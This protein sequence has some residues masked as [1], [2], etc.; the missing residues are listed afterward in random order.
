MTLST[1]YDV[2]RRPKFK[3][4]AIEPEV[5]VAVSNSVKLPT[6]DNVGSVTDKSGMVTNVVIA[7]VIGSHAHSVK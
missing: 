3:M 4:T 1:L 7:V 6:S 2:G 5:G